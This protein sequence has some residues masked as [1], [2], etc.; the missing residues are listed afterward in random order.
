M[1]HQTLAIVGSLLLCS[2]ATGPAKEPY[3]WKGD[4]SDITMAKDREQCNFEAEKVK[5]GL[6][7][8]IHNTTLAYDRVLDQCMKAKGYR[9]G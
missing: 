7:W 5:A 3:Y 4:A 6:D 9:A 8:R 2:C 1:K